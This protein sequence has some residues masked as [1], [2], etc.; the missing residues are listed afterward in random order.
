MLDFLGMSIGI[1]EFRLGLGELGWGWMRL[2]DEE[3]GGERTAVGGDG[4]W[5]EENGRDIGRYTNAEQTDRQTEDGRTDRQR[6]QTNKQRER[7]RER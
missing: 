5:R 7:E 6:A 4:E 3:R 2:L 1:D